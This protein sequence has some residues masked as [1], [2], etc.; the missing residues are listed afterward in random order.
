MSANRNNGHS[1]ETPKELSL[2]LS[3][4]LLFSRL[5]ST[6]I[7]C[8]Y[9]CFVNNGP[10]PIKSLAKRSTL[11]KHAHYPFWSNF[12]SPFFSNLRIRNVVSLAIA[13]S[14]MS[15]SQAILSFGNRSNR[16][17]GNRL[18]IPINSS[19]NKISC[20]SKCPIVRWFPRPC[21]PIQ[22]SC[23]A[24]ASRCN[25]AINRCRELFNV[26]VIINP[27]RVSTFACPPEWS[28]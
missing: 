13:A 27:P 20:L 24:R 8:H 1:F 12:S 6:S 19:I 9:D 10:R 23:L 21:D 25:C 26:I 28:W 7:K 5:L 3:L 4:F 2:S 11:G 15:L 18:F 14:R 16:S 22:A 17:A